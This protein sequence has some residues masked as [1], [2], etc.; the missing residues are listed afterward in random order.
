MTDGPVFD[1]LHNHRAWFSSSVVCLDFF[2][3]FKKGRVGRGG[4]VEKEQRPYRERSGARGKVKV[5]S[6]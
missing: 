2:F 6:G 5:N 4:V 3:F 1:A